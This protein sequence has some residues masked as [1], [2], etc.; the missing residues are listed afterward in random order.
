MNRL[1]MVDAIRRLFT[2]DGTEEELD[3][4]LDRLVQAVPHADISDMIYYPDQDRSAEQIADEALRRE[5]EHAAKLPA[6]SAR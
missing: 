3:Q 5:R 4:L 6:A 2:A 1:S